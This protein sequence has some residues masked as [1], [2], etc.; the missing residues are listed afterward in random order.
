VLLVH[1]IRLCN[2][3]PGKK[4]QCCGKKHAV[5]PHTMCDTGEMTRFRKKKMTRFL[6]KRL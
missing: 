3:T 6:S 5:L 2:F 4:T 1:M